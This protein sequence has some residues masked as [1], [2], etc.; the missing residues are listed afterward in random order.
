MDLG[1][2]R[3]ERLV[4]L[5]ALAGALFA[6]ASAQAAG[7]QRPG[8]SSTPSNTE[9]Y[10]ACG[11][12][13]PGHAECLAIL[14][15][16]ASARAMSGPLRQ[17][18]P[19][20]V[21]PSFSGSGVGGGYAPAD[22]RSAYDLPSA[23]AGSGQT[24]AIVD[25]FDDPNAESDLA[26]YRSRYGLS[27]CTTGNGCFRKVNQSGGTK[28]PTPEPG[29]A[30]E[31][32][33][34]LDMVS[35]ACPNC[36]I[37]LVEAS[38]N[39]NGNL[40]AAE[41]E[42]VALGA[43]EVSDS[44]AGNEFS[45][46]TSQDSHFHH[47]GVPITASAGDFG[48]GVEYPAASPYVIAVGGTSLTHAS[49]LR[50]WSETAWSG[51][52]SGC[53]AFEPKPAWQTDGGCANRTNGDVSAVASPETP[54][55][56]ADSYKLPSEF[57]MPEPGWTLVAGTSVSSPLV[58]G[59]VALANA[60][61][62]S[63]PGADAFYKEVAQGGAGALND[64]T[65]GNNVKSGT[66]N[67]GNYLCN[68]GRG[69]DGPTGLGTPSGAP[70]VAFPKWYKN[71]TLVDE[72]IRIPVVEWGTVTLT[73]ARGAV[74]CNSIIGG[75]VENPVGGG[76]G[77]GATESLNTYE[78]ST[79]ECP[80]ETRVEAF[81]TPWSSELFEE[82]GVIRSR[83]GTEARP[84]DE[85]IG[86]WAGAPTGPGNEAGEKTLKQEQENIA[87]RGTPVTMPLAFRGML[88]PKL[89]GGSGASKP[90]LVQFGEGSGE[91]VSE[92]GKGKTS[93]KVKLL[94][95][96]EQELIVAS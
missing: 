18:G 44:W 42:A 50:G 30:V 53:S 45:G 72:G 93:G 57:S 27:A 87:E 37:L 16:S 34:D 31:I 64:V 17:P 15:P 49:N 12:P 81:D 61:T 75:Y 82:A 43:T 48:Y 90:S 62:R 10:A 74:A 47:P 71:G 13:A 91:L 6:N 35:A 95:Y 25:A 14:V 54:V 38:N 11:R 55:S 60:Y 80:Q 58:A 94:G 3:S 46:E 63:F 77:I 76:P 39:I 92:S 23:S 32:S 89:T 69:Y 5:I 51:T 29:W 36:H 88:T 84:V 78:C 7:A 4:C 26:V 2:S 9:P 28:Y 65:S 83:N 52:G 86:C 73:S 59:I 40:F 24:V 33:L 1:P 22:L 41:D 66:E 68:A 20:Q 79:A 70:T 96:N 21:S 67:C 85:V 19:A 8:F 56:V